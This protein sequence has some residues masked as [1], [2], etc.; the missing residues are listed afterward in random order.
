MLDK[1]LKKLKRNR[2]VCFNRRGLADVEMGFDLSVAVAV[3]FIAL[4]GVAAENG[5]IML[6]YLAHALAERRAEVARAGRAFTRADLNAAIM[7]G[8]LSVFGQRW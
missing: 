5:V 8:Q 1:A 6:I 3:G 2:A 7:V 4:A